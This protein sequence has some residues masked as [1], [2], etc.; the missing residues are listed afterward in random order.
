PELSVASALRQRGLQEIG[1]GLRQ[2]ARIVGF[3]HGQRLLSHQAMPSD[4]MEMIETSLSTKCMFRKYGTAKPGFHQTLDGL[5]IVG[6]H[7]HMRG[8]ADLVEKVVDD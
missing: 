7:D 1:D 2:L 3:G 8:E 6:F 4:A 5:S